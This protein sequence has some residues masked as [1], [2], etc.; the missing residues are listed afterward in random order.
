[1]RAGLV[2]SMRRLLV[3][4]V[5]LVGL[6]SGQSAFAQHAACP[7][8]PKALGVSR[9][10]EIDTSS[11]PR[12]GGKKKDN[13]FLTRG[14]V[15]LTFDDGPIRGPTRAV[16]NAL[17]AHCVKATFFVVGRMAVADPDM[18]REY[19]RR[20]HSVGTHTWSHAKLHELPPLEARREIELGISA[21]Q[22]AMGKPIAPFFRFP[23]LGETRAMLQH[24]QGRHVANFGIDID[25]KDYR[26]LEAADVVSQVMADLAV[27]GKGV[28][29]FHDIH[30]ATARALPALLNELKSNGYRVVHLVA[31]EG[32]TTDAEFDAIAAR[33]L[34]RKSIASRDPMAKR[35]ATWPV[36]GT[37]VAG[38]ALRVPADAPAKERL[39][40]T[41]QPA[42]NAPLVDWISDLFR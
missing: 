12:I 2:R 13:E 7:A 9:V 22:L 3:C 42:S 1:M 26:A 40:R 39:P 28:I 33:T 36:S 32:A 38:A 35:A 31:K 25:S 34:A 15:V 18:V 10:I 20:G 14:E 30:A 37:P 41:P 11:G 24:V 27:S 6:L 19:D 17:D 29:L 5:A 23:Y 16:L 21:V 4:G 8:G